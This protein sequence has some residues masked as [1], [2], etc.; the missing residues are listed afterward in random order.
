MVYGGDNMRK[1][2][3]EFVAENL[4]DARETAYIE[5]AKQLSSEL[6]LKFG[7]VEKNDRIFLWDFIIT[8]YHGRMYGKGIVAY[9]EDNNVVKYV[10]HML[11]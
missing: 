6:I 4:D 9:D 2:E 1:Y 10:I 11:D 8:D 7:I 5:I 3:E